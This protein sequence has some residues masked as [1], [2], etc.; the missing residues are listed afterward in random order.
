MIMV[1][2][3]GN[4]NEIGEDINGEYNQELPP[5]ILKEPDKGRQPRQEATGTI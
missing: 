2:K 1:E 3:M 4:V 5:V